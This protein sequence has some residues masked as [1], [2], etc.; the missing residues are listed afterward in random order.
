MGTT[1]MRRDEYARCEIGCTHDL[2]AGVLVTDLLGGDGP[3]NE[4]HP[5]S[6]PIR[7]ARLRPQIAPLENRAA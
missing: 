6:G 1:R 3:I 7:N 4:P 2:T 5:L